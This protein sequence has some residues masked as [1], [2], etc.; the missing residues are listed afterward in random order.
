M[1]KRLS[2]RSGVRCLLARTFLPLPSHSCQHFNGPGHKHILICL[3]ETIGRDLIARALGLSQTL[4]G[5]L[6][7]QKDLV[8]RSLANLRDEDLRF[9]GTL[10]R[11]LL[12]SLD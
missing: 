12:E 7:D 3:S 1:Q 10:S 8:S 9:L 4:N 5:H 6:Q 11:R 2:T